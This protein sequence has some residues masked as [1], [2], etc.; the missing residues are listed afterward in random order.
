M[1]TI[2]QLKNIHAC[3]YL[4]VLSIFLL[5][6]ASILGQ[7]KPLIKRTTYKNENIKFGAGGTITIVGAPEGSITIEGWQKNEIEI[8]ADIEVE[9]ATE[10][11][12]A[13]LSKI[14]GFVLDEGFGHVRVLTVGTNDKSYIKRVTKKFPKHLL[15][16]SFKIDYRLKVPVYSD[17]E[18]NGGN[19]NL[20]LSNVEGAMQIRILQGDAALSLTGGTIRG[21]FGSGNVDIKIASRNWRGRSA[22]FQ[23]ATGTMNIELPQNMHADID[24][25]VLRTGKIENSIVALKPREKMKFTE[26]SMTARAGNGGA[27][28]SFTVG[29]GTMVIKN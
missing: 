7:T 2:L 16:S 1:K 15:N 28:L 29:D 3:L 9:A 13:E 21:V 14:N 22:D 19:G 23:L 20:N 26:K 4:S 5:S 6:P 18:I 10:A 12:L 11:D 17:L 8:S 24:A 25:S 27:V